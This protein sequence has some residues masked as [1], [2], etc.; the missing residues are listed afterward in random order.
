MLDLSLGKNPKISEIL[1]GFKHLSKSTFLGVV[2]LIISIVIILGV[3]P[4]ALWL[5]A[6][7]EMTYI[8]FYLE[9]NN[10]TIK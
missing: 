8:N 7:I 6:Y 1:F 2:S 10:S 3:I 5:S 4:Y 9:L